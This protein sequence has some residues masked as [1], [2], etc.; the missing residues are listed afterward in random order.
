M[1]QSLYKLSHVT[2]SENDI[3]WNSSILQI[4]SKQYNSITTKINAILF[5]LPIYR[6]RSFIWSHRP[7]Y[8]NYEKIGLWILFALDQPPWIGLIQG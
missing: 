5:W 1:C 2:Q 8:K 7:D 4:L 6:A 3:F